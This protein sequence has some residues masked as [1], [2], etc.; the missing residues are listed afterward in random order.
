MK[1]SKIILGLLTT[2]FALGHSTEKDVDVGETVNNEVEEES[3]PTL[4]FNIT[5]TILEKPGTPLTEFVE[6]EENDV[7]TLYYNFTN[8]DET[9]VTIT[10]ASGNILN[11]PYGHMSANISFGALENLHVGVNETVVFDQ[12]VNFRIPEGEYYLLPIIHVQRHGVDDYPVQVAV[13][14]SHIRI[15]LPVLSIFN[16]QFLSIVF[17]ILIAIGGAYFFFVQPKIEKKIKKSSSSKVT[18]DRTE[19]LPEQYKK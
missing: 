19:W 6:F 15:V 11:Y 10:G 5:Y 1:F 13:D 3:I 12:R 16:L 9:N 14:F 7:A 18:K 4:P 8:H 17:S 2:S